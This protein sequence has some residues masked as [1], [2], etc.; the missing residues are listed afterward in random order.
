MHCFYYYSCCCAAAAVVVGFLHLHCAL[1]IVVLQLLM[2]LLL[3]L[4]SVMPLC[5]CLSSRYLLGLLVWLKKCTFCSNVHTIDI[6]MLNPNLNYPGISIRIRNYHRLFW[7]TNIVS[8][9]NT[10]RHDRFL[11]NSICNGIH[12]VYGSSCV[13][14]FCFVFI[15]LFFIYFC[16]LVIAAL[17]THNVCS[18]RKWMNEFIFSFA[19]RDSRAHSQPLRTN[20]ESQLNL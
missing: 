6:L 4:I 19:W 5:L 10:F 9:F 15:Y 13:S 8:F 14:V 3:L 12:S 11:F 18:Q 17:H 1:L 16:L 20:A 7:R 2:L